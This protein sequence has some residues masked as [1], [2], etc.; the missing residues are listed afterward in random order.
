VQELIDNTSLNIN[1][2]DEATLKLMFTNRGQQKEALQDA[3]G[4][5]K[6]QNVQQ[7]NEQKEL[8][9]QQ[10]DWAQIQTDYLN[11]KVDF[12]EYSD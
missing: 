6:V 10:K 8:Q 11:S 4:L 9:Q 2:Y 7:K 3:K 12:N 1:D 5:K